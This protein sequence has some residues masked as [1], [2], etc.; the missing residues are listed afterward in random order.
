MQGGFANRPIQRRESPEPK[1]MQHSRSGLYDPSMDDETAMSTNRDHRT[2]TCARPKAGQRNREAHE[3]KPPNRNLCETHERRTSTAGTP[4]NSPHS[5]PPARP[6][7]TPR[8]T[9]A[10]V[11]ALLAVA[12]SAQQ[13]MIVSTRFARNGTLLR[14]VPCTSAEPRRTILVFSVIGSFRRSETLRKK[15]TADTTH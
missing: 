14:S 2:A 11:P 5:R 6:R 12:A 3:S 8:P 7:R 9:S 15:R 4:T 10:P 1:F 13:L